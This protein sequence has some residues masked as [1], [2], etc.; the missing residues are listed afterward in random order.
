MRLIDTGEDIDIATTKESKR[1]DKK[2]II[3][4]FPI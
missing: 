2:A 3:I 4:I 1:Y